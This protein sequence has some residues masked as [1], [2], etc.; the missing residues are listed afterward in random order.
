MR[1]VISK[2]GTAIAFDQSG[3]GP[4]IILVAG[5]FT[6]RSQPIL[7]QLAE[8]LSPQFTVI[9]YDRRGRGNSGDTPPYAVERE[10]E[11]LDALIKEAGGAAFVCGFS[12]GAAL[13]LE[14]A[15]RR[16][17][18]KKLVL[19]EPP[20]RIAGGPSQLPQDF[21]EHLSEF[22]SSGRRGDAAEY[23]MVQAA[24]MPAEA[25]AQMRNQP[26]WPMVESVAH[27]LVYDT[28]V[29]GNDALL[30]PERLT[31]IAVPALVIDGGA[32]PEW[33]RAAAQAVAEALPHA[34]RRTLE[35][36]THEVSPLV[37]APVLT[38][39]FED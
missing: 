7:T 21:A 39:F 10:I 23:F 19:Y 27:T 15:A 8:I 17:A 20:F 12:S 5:A 9:N 18:L 11:D 2:D 34:Q 29:M 30:R 16:L 26:F 36:Q 4:A 35:G 3:G 25:V 32:S 28:A 37:L 13:T 1:R 33:M 6:D 22:V 14:A 31:S 24:V 38:E